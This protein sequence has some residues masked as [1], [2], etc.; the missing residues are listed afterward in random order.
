MTSFSMPESDSAIE[1]FTSIFASKHK[2][3]NV[4]SVIK[5]KYLRQMAGRITRGSK[6][7]DFEY[8]QKDGPAAKKFAWVMGD[9]GLSLFLVQSNLEALR[10]IGCEDKWIR[11][12][13]EN[14]EYFQ[15][16]I[17][18]RSPECLLATWD[19]V[20]SLIDI[21]YPKSISAKIR[22]HEK[23]L[24]QMSFDE[25]EARARLSYL[26]GATYFDINELAVN[27]NSA[28]PRFMS[29]ERFLECEGTLE[30]SRGFLYNRL[31]L[32]KLFDGSGF[33]KNSSGQLG[34]REYLQP[35]IPVR[36]IPGFRYLNLPID[37]TDLM[38]DS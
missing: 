38:P 4:N 33:T 25:I 12:K 8:L 9:D 13:L 3:D 22:R 7:T 23:A 28:D 6:E 34:V 20:L 15:L 29:E 10:S 16:G 30:E 5:N 18:Y 14:G 17:F 2:L 11:R 19:G 37:T 26:H 32:A 31:G 35:N 1:A 21:Y 36:D 27:G 24:K